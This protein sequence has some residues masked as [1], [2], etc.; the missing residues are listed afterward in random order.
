MRFNTFGPGSK[1]HASNYSDNLRTDLGQGFVKS[2]RAG[3][4]VGVGFIGI[5]LVIG[6]ISSY[7]GAAAQAMVDRLNL[8]LNVLDVGWR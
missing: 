3:L 5:N 1:C 6:L 2:F 8:S 7:A 4:T